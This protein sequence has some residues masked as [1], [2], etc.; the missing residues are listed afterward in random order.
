MYNHHKYPDVP[1]RTLNSL[2]QW[3][4]NTLPPGSFGMAVLKNDLT[5][6][7]GR[8]DRQNRNSLPRIV[9][10]CYNELPNRCWGSEKAVKNWKE[11]DEDE[12]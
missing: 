8:A 12:N 10:Y 2:D 6:A 4:K 11:R 1:D 9:E 7:V 5:E 3:A